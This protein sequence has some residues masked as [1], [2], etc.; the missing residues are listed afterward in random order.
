MT[1]PV[2]GIDIGGTK[3]AAAL[4]DRVG[5]VLERREV[6]TPAR[7]GPGAVLDAAARLATD[8]LGASTGPVGV[9]TAGT[10]DPATGGIRYATDSL[11]G[12][13]GTPVAD[14]LAAR[15]GRG[16]RVT[17]D[18]N[19]AALGECWAGAGRDRAHV[20]LVA[21]GTG[22]GGAVVRN[23]RVEAGVRGAAGE[24]GHLP[25][26]GAERL[27]C[28]CGRY[29]HLEA[30]ASGSGLAAAYSIETGTHVTGRTVADR[31]AAGDGVA[32][33]VVERAGTVLGAALAGLV[34]LLDPDAVLV[35]G[36]A[37]GAL[38]PAA[39]AAYSAEVPAGWADVPLL[40]ATLGADAVVVGAARLAID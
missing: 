20:L 14:A 17:N 7:S 32:Q 6:P 34:A 9:G 33:Q 40:P 4:V 23:G 1:T 13:T 2:V 37:A 30:I 31:A 21:V 28:G 29:G 8:L 24:V 25:A 12:W 18:V 36:G 16:V 10:V 22:L 26:P 11:P 38:L 3:T 5:Q 27:R 19:A 35:T 39:S 15:L